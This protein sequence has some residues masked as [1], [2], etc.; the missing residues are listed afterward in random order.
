[1]THVEHSP[2]EG[3]QNSICKHERTEM[4]TF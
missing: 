2:K 4:Q 1:V 3:V